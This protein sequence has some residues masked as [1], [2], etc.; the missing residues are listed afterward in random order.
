MATFGVSPDYGTA[1]PADLSSLGLG[2]IPGD[3]SG[4]SGGGGGGFFDSLGNWVSGLGNLAEQG[5]QT[6]QN[7][8]GTNPYGTGTTLPPS[9]GYP[10]IQ[11]QNP[12]LVPAVPESNSN[13]LEYV[14]IGLL[15]LVL[16][17]R[18]GN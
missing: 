4:G 11:Y 10:V 14:A 15:L 18:K 5:Y 17:L 3:T 13:L 1:N 8:T 12:G 7:I 6:Y 16:L 9:G 2:S